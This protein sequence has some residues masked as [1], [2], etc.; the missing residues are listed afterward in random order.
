M[1]N[2]P[3]ETA[4]SND[5]FPARKFLDTSTAHVSPAARDWLDEQ[6]RI[7]AAAVT[8]QDEE[9]AIH[10]GRLVTGWFFYADENPSSP[11]LGIPDDVIRLMQEARKRGCE[12]VLLD[13][14]A[15]PLDGLPTYEW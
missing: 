13:R 9:P 11:Y 2:I 1:T 6:G 14:D 15:E 10:I 3:I 12:Y 7:A 4:A 5:E 8:D